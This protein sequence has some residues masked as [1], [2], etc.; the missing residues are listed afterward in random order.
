[1]QTVNNTNLAWV[2]DPHTWQTHNS[3]VQ[4]PHITCDWYPDVGTFLKAV[5]NKNYHVVCVKADLLPRT[6]LS[7]ADLGSVIRTMCGIHH[8]GSPHVVVLIDSHT[9]QQWLKM[10]Q[11]EGY[12]GMLP[13]A[14]WQ[15]VKEFEQAWQHVMAGADYWP[16]RM[17]SWYVPH[18]M[19]HVK[20]AFKLTPRQTQVLQLIQTRGSSNKMIAKQLKISESTVKVHIGA[21]MKKFGVRNRTQL[22]VSAIQNKL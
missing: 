18:K 21:I 14:T 7:Q 19:T 8:D 6:M 10:A 3:H 9:D 16:K 22:A 20:P 5:C 13:D 15:S 4:S 1:M 11:S 2:S 12:L 17:W